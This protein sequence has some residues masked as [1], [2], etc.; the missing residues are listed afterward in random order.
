M[1]AAG[2]GFN[3]RGVDHVTR[4]CRPARWWCL[5][6]AALAL[7]CQ[8]MTPDAWAFAL[9]PDFSTPERAGR[10]FLC[11][12]RAE[13]TGTEYLGLAE[14]L[15]REFGATLDGYILYRQELADRAGLGSLFTHLLEVVEREEVEEGVLLWW[16][17]KQRPRIGLLMVPQHYFDL[18]EAGGRDRRVGDFL[19]QTP[20]EVLILEGRHLS[21]ELDNPA[22]RAATRFEALGAFHLGTEW[23]LRQVVLPPDS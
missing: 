20:G 4:F 8:S 12:W 13:E 9:H 11:A 16:G 3:I 6:L 10:S 5:P 2:L 17:W 21:L 19:D 23:K 22:V 14:D 18:S 1:P 7:S 15:K